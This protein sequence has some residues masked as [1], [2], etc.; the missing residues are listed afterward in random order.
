MITILESKRGEAVITVSEELLKESGIVLYEELDVEACEGKL[1]LSS[2][3][4]K[5][6]NL[7]AMVEDISIENQSREWSIGQVGREAW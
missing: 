1:V 5:R 6:L 3:Q 2:Q 7:R 4:P